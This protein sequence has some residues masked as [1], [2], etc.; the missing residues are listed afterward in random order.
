MHRPLR[1]VARAVAADDFAPVRA[2]IRQAMARPGRRTLD[3]GCGPGL[4]ADLFAGEDYVGLDR[5]HRNVAWARSVRPGAFLTSDPRRIDLPDGR[6]DQAFSFALL[7][8][9][10]DPDVATL[11]REL[12]RLI[13]PGG[14]ALVI[15]EVPGDDGWARLRP[16]L[17]GKS[18]PR[19]LAALPRLLGTG[20]ETF[21]SGLFLFAQAAVRWD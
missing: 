19:P 2:R 21:R 15:T 9:L 16:L 10:S 7:E 5:S 11:L 18:P 14:F 8:T 13:V 4:F 20:V 1:F 12:R 3:V 6:F 17:P